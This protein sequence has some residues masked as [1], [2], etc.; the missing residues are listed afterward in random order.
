[1]AF[2]SLSR[3]FY[4]WASPKWFLQ[5]AQSWQPWLLSL[6]SVLLITGLIWGLAIAPEERYQ[7][8]SYRIIYIHVPA[9]ILAQNAYILLAIAGFVFLVWRVKLAE[10]F[11]NQSASVGA[12]FTLLALL[13]GSIWG[14]PV[15]GTWWF[16]DARLISTLILLFLYLGI[17]ALYSALRE[18][19]IAGKA[20]SI[21]ALVG[22]INIPII[23]YSVDWWYSLHQPASFTLTQKPAMP[24]EMWLPLLLMV[25]GYFCFYGWVV[26]KR[27]SIELMAGWPSLK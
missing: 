20:A 26:L 15:W 10:L 24:V 3:W 22:V 23:K 25:F 17:I 12:S 5:R 13:S 6:A 27:M 21:L 19:G 16:G 14:K 9:A 2:A 1:M 8:N 11:I 18:R 7:G 4:L